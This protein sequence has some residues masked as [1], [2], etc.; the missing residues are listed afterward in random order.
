[1]SESGLLE[2]TFATLQ[3]QYSADISDLSDETKILEPLLKMV[4][5]EKGQ[6]LKWFTSGNASASTGNLLGKAPRVIFKRTKG[7]VNRNGVNSF[8][9]PIIGIR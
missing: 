6:K 8:S 3:S 2:C 1:M 9:H 5:Q 7:L 4:N